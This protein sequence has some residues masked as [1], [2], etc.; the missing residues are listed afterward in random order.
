MLIYCIYR[1][2][3]CYHVTRLY[4]INR[5]IHGCN[6]CNTLRPIQCQTSTQDPTL[7][8][9]THTHT[10]FCNLEDTGST[11]SLISQEGQQREYFEFVIPVYQ[12]FFVFSG[13]LPRWPNPHKNKSHIVQ[14]DLHG[15]HAVV[16]PC[17]IH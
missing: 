4:L 12:V 1:V 13:K 10:H 16:P 14:S 8:T 6:S 3:A 11:F 17:P 7:C 9:H 2:P 15:D 5:M